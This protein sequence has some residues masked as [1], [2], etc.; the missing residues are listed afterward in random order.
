MIFSLV[1]DL[2]FLLST[3]QKRQLLSIQI[4]F[5]I[6]TF[7]EIIGILSIIPFVTLVSNIN[8]IY[9]KSYLS[10][11]FFYFNFSSE[12]FF[13]VCLGIL[14]LLSLIISSLFS[15]FTFWRIFMFGNQLGI[16]IGDRLFNYYM[17]QGWI[18]YISKNSSTYTKKISVEAQ[19]VTSGI[20]IPLLQMNAK[21]LFVFF[22]VISIAIYNPLIAFIGASLFTFSYMTLYKS[23]KNFVFNNG[24]KVSEMY[25]KRFS[26]MN[27]AFGGKK[28]ILLL[29]KIKQSIIQFEEA[30]KKISFSQ[31]TNNTL[32]HVPRYFFELI[33][34]GSIIAFII[35]LINF[36]GGNLQKIIPTL[37]IF[38]IAGYKLLPSIQQVFA[39]ITTIRGNLAA[40]NDIKDDLKNSLNLKVDRKNLTKEKLSIKK[41]IKFLN[42]NF[43]YPSRTSFYI[44]NL[45]L[46]IE[47]K[48]S[49]GIIGSTGSGK[50]TIIDILTGLIK[51]NSG[52]LK[53]D[54]T[55]I[56]YLNL[57]K[58]QNN[59][60]YVSQNIFLTDG[61]IMENIAL[62][63][64]RE[65]INIDKI[66][67]SI[68][69]ASL[70]SFIE[71][72]QDNIHTKVGER[73]IQL[74]GGQIQRIGIARS[75]Y[76]ESD[77]L[78]FD[79]ATSALDVNTERKIIDSI[80]NL[81]GQKTII[82]IAHRLTTVNRCDHIYLIDKGSVRAQGKYDDLVIKNDYFKL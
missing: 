77:I 34:F 3:N 57:R 69:L 65:N 9:E 45:N 44:N 58:W 68:K 46:K 23:I 64:N 49:V 39:Y 71:S 53:V 7:L 6:A 29:G 52:C 72:L 81:K 33:T 80:Y 13:L 70:D 12:I 35:Y 8:L 30:G 76:N 15:I 66:K 56:N 43:S 20:I 32:V 37:S 17:E 42:I 40:F 60:S 61:S 1:K 25:D 36:E 14:I 59:L 27:N 31:G 54:D 21:I 62:G 26:I 28:E 4:F 16:E 10:D 67:Q 41:E 48:S 63:A 19:R 5:I 2:I 82:F 50:S 24:Q 78:I 79:E 47:A 73:G 74:S 55:E 51:P 38:V 22:I 75:L 11:L 18:S